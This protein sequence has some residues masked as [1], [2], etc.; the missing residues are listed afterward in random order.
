HVECLRGY[1][2]AQGGVAEVRTVYE[3]DAVADYAMTDNGST[4]FRREL[5]DAKREGPVELVTFDMGRGT[6]D[7]SIVRFKG[8]SQEERE[9]G[10]AETRRWRHFQKAR[11]GRSDG[12]NKL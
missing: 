2:E 4:R 5:R 7:L 8:S 9:H 3:S 10:L 6:T 1:V 11:T 12:G